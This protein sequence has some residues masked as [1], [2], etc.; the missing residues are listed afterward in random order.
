MQKST[1]TCFESALKKQVNAA[2]IVMTILVVFFVLLTNGCAARKSVQTLDSEARARA[3]DYFV[4][5]RECDMRGMPQLALQYLERAAALDTSAA[6]LREQ[7]IDHYVFL[8]KYPQAILLLKGKRKDRDLTDTEKEQLSG[9]HMRMGETAKA[10]ELMEMVR[11]KKK[12]DWLV[13]GLMYES[14]GKVS[15]SLACYELCRSQMPF[16]LDMTLKVV[17]M[18]IYLKQ[19]AGAESVLVSAEQSSAPGTRILNAH[20]ELKLTLHDTT[21]ARQYFDRALLIDS[22]DQESVHNAGE[23][24]IQSGSYDKAIILYEKLRA[25]DSTNV[26]MGKTLAFLYYNAHSWDKS[27]TLIRRLLEENV[28]NE[29]LHYFLG[30]IYQAQDSDELARSEFEKVL[31][32]SP[33]FTDAWLQLCSIELRAKDNDAAISVA[34]RYVAAAPEDGVAWRNQGY[35]YNVRKEYD[36][37]L[38]SL[39]NA[40]KRDSSDVIAWFEYA[41]AQERAQHFDSAVSAFRHVLHIKP[42]DAGAANYLGY[43][44]VDKGIK[45]DSAAILLK[46]ALA[47]DSL[48]G[49]FLDSY[50]WLCFKKGDVDGAYLYI[51]KALSQIKDDATVYAH[52]GY[53]L[54]KKGDNAGA[55]DAFV[56][57]L[58][59]DPASDDAEGVRAR[60]NKY[61]SDTP[62]SAKHIDLPVKK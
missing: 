49:A 30:L 19:Y 7:L 2:G 26:L 4:S 41:S 61:K 27:K 57:S 47:A 60:L 45:L 17:G 34:K 55:V 21:A 44:Y 40:I 58:S 50:A 28:D 42:D 11:Q 10:A 3:E 5:A 25:R 23:L 48:N 1:T 43:M 12:E 36:K 59:I 16:S 22:S 9:I 29:Q 32:I 14:L 31:V 46:R 56:K 24:L 37:A 62:S 54:E 33:S 52:Y 6:T 13:L 53:I 39:A 18:N 20:G 38:L 35:V 8:S 15:R 51:T